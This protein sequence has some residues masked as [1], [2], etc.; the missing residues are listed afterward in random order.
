LLQ[1]DR[2]LFIWYLP[3]ISPPA[4]NIVHE[5]KNPDLSTLDS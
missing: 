4:W 3:D 5:S 2:C 1:V